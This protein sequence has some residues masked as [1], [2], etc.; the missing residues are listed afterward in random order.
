M[1]LSAYSRKKANRNIPTSNANAHTSCSN[2]TLTAHPS[3]HPRYPSIPSQK[4]PHNIS[5]HT[6]PHRIPNKLTKCT[7]S[8]NRPHSPL[9]IPKLRRNR[10]LPLIPDT[11]IQQSLIAPHDDLTFSPSKI[12]RRATV[13]AGVELGAVGGEGAAV[14]HGDAV[15]ALGFAGAGV[16][17]G[18]FGCYFC[19]EGE[20]EEEREEG[21]DGE[22][23]GC[24]LVSGGAIEVVAVCDGF[25]KRQEEQFEGGV[26]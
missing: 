15:A 21:E 23:H 5:T 7:P 13:G 25:N 8:R 6:L 10:Q 18:V 2:S 17:D 20:G 1:F 4:L 12:Q 16:F 3:T 9:P 11:H 26:R 14:V 24:L 22:T 19:G